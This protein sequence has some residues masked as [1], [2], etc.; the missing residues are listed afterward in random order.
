MVELRLP[1]P[2][3]IIFS[4]TRKNIAGIRLSPQKVR[5]KKKLAELK[6]NEL[7]AEPKNLFDFHDKTPQMLVKKPE[8][9]E[10]GIYDVSLNDSVYGTC[11]SLGEYRERVAMAKRISSVNGNCIPSSSTSDAAQ[12]EVVEGKKETAVETVPDTSAKP[13][14]EKKKRA[15]SKK[16]T[17]GNEEKRMRSRSKKR[18]ADSDS[19]E[20]TTYVK[21]YQ[22]TVKG[23]SSDAPERELTRRARSKV[24][25]YKEV[26]SDFDL[27]LTEVK[28]LAPLKN[29]EENQKESSAKTKE[30]KPKE[31]KPKE[32]TASDY[33]DI[34]SK[35]ATKRQTGRKSLKETDEKPTRSRKKSTAENKNTDHSDHL[36]SVATKN[37]VAEKSEIVLKGTERI[38][39]LMSR[40]EKLQTKRSRSQH[41]SETKSEETQNPTEAVSKPKS[42]T[43]DIVERYKQALASYNDTNPKGESKKK[44]N[45]KSRSRPARNETSDKMCQN[46]KGRSRSL[47]AHKS[48][49]MDDKVE[50]TL[51]RKRSRSVAKKKTDE[52]SP[53]S[54]PVKKQEESPEVVRKGKTERGRSKSRAR[55]NAKSSMTGTTSVENKPEKS[56]DSLQRKIK[57][58]RGRSRSRVILAK[59]ED[60]DAMCNKILASDVTEVDKCEVNSNHMKKVKSRSIAGKELL[61]KLK[62]L[63]D[64]EENKVST[65][66]HMLNTDTN[67]RKSAETNVPESIKKVVFLF[68]LFFFFFGLSP[69]WLFSLIFSAFSF[70]SLFFLLYFSFIFFPFLFTLFY[71]FHF[72]LVFSFS[73]FVSFSLSFFLF[74]S[75]SSLFLSLS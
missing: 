44:E 17:D 75:F 39:D 14:E 27:T 31:E 52:P 36:L 49:S 24:I 28:A 21:H 7:T 3:K 68:Y 37:S 59:N 63:N 22:K 13:A 74:S 57:N 46:Q 20:D 5:S 53:P 67:A 60:S 29:A 33:Q 16:A 65:D 19:D 11:Q 54:S 69:F 48:D 35:N 18:V 4:A 61:L 6:K 41:R 40:L 72:S 1:K 2:G 50:S 45:S 64:D 66:T 73:F 38:A 15:R 25:S 51:E 71:L 62:S 43:S 26:E 8:P 70:L 30:E 9:A 47:H 42:T 10:T 58:E 34:E 23:V 56:P 12:T 32:E 55:S